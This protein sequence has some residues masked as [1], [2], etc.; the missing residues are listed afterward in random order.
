M[1]EKLLTDS[2][3]RLP[4]PLQ[5]SDLIAPMECPFPV[6]YPHIQRPDLVKL[7]NDPLLV[8][9]KSLEVWANWVRQKYFR[10]E[11]G[12]ALGYSNSWTEADLSFWAD[13]I[14]QSFIKALP[15][16]PVGLGGSLPWLGIHRPLS[17]IEFFLGLS[18]CLQE[19]FVVM[20]PKKT[21]PHLANPNPSIPDTAA[22]D[23]LVAG[24]VSVCFPS[25]WQPLEKIDKTFFEIHLPVA[26][27]QKIQQAASS[28]SRAMVSRGPFVRYVYTIAPS[29]DLWRSPGP[30]NWPSEISD[31][32]TLWFRVERQI[33]IPLAGLGSLFLIRVFVAPLQKV[34]I[35][36][37]RAE[38]LIHAIESMSSTLLTY[39]GLDRLVPK[40]LPILKDF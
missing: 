21:L 12:G 38:R 2:P 8:T 4:G 16:G 10:L 39:K 40:L 22:P 20:V 33:T 25:G 14:Q 32:S 27:N 13:Q 30:I 26:D 36:K 23:E 1:C 6:H 18:L 29:G 9:D 35:S 24:L 3:D 28:L 31:L 7:G 34:L 11:H 15:S 5:T 17:S 37:E 19:D